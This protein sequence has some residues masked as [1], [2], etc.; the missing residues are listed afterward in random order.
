MYKQVIKMNLFNK[1]KYYLKKIKDMCA[2]FDKV[3]SKALKMEQCNIPIS[4]NMEF[5][6]LIHSVGEELIQCGNKL[7]SSS[8]NICI[9]HH[10][11]DSIQLSSIYHVSVHGHWADR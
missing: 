2:C 4:E 9:A 6:D 10:S 3:A 1:A 5:A 7:Q 11:T 8:V